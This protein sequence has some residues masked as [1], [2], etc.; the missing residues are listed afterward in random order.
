[1]MKQVQR[2]AKQLYEMDQVLFDK[3]ELPVFVPEKI[4]DAQKAL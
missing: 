3:I 1:M 2:R 4:L